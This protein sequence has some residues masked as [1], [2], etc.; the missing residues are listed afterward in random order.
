MILNYFKIA[1]RS[2]F[3][4]KLYTSL[5]IAGLTFGLTCFIL[6]ALYVF[7]EL[8]YDR[9]FTNSARTYRVIEQR[10]TEGK[11]SLIPA[12]SYLLGGE[13]KKTIPEIEQVTRF[14]GG[15]RNNISNP[16]N[17]NKFYETMWS[18]DAAFLEIF[19][20]PLVDGDRVNALKDP[21]S[22]V[23]TEDLAIKL[24]NSKQ[25]VGKMVRI[26]D[27]RLYKVTA[28]LKELPSNTSFNFNLLISESTYSEFDFYKDRITSDW[29][30]NTQNT[31]VVLKD[32]AN[33]FTVSSRM[34]NLV[35]A[36]RPKTSGITVKYSL[37][38]LN[39]I[40]FHSSHMQ[41]APFRSGNRMYIFIFSLVA[42]FLLVIACINYMNLTTAHASNRFKEIGI[43]KA[44]GA[45]RKNLAWQFLTESALITGFSFI[46]SVLLVNAA[47][48][49]FNQFVDKSLSLGFATDYRIWF[50]AIG[51]ALL[52]SLL[53]G[54]YP[55]IMLS[56][57]QPVSLLKNLVVRKSGGVTLRRSLVV[58]QF[59]LSVV[60]II[61]TIVLYQ[62]IQF[63]KNKNLGFQQDQLVVVDI[64]S[65]LVRRNA[66]TIKSE[67]G[68]I[69]E[70]QSVSSSSRVPGEW[71]TIPTV[72]IKTPGDTREPQNAYLIGADENFAKTFDI[73]LLKGRNFINPGDTSSILLNETAAALLGIDQAAEQ[74][75][76]IP[77]ANFGGSDS[78]LNQVFKARVIGITK[79]FH[80]QSLREKIAPLVLAYRNNP[81]HS[82]DYFTAW[83]KTPDASNALDEMK[84]VLASIDPNHLF[85]HHFLDEQLALFYIEDKRRET[86]L[87]WVALAIVFISCLGLFGLATYAAEQRIKEI[88]VRK[89]LGASV[90]GISSLL[91]KDFLKLVLIANGVAFPVAY[92]VMNKW[93]NEFAYRIDIDVWVFV[94]AGSLALLIALLTVG[95]QAIRAAIA[96]P[97]KSLRM[98]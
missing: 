18:T 27:D 43:R 22:V 77:S 67:F 86:I 93:L 3:R 66:E 14:F 87:I 51:F 7:N 2:F 44:A 36:N 82:I 24:F 98:E 61:A 73:Q 78:P 33:P 8:T 90:L 12:V 53:S 71:K 19:D 72:K 60:M 41:G 70:V 37:Q 48:P 83:L 62:Q 40:Y 92:Y 32:R 42:L 46:L 26:G 23:L 81:V 35:E 20:H 84:K 85:E 6:I 63:I 1:Y 95:F 56:G 80:F 58:F 89:V 50:G 96:N 31:F 74:W 10:T 17:L 94:V 69:A 54:S 75:V 13:S 9:H 28:V 25:V 59:T 30:S 65:G 68:R 21:Y 29:S 47:L 64:N 45:I 79:D 11:E 88:G 5:N 55:A 34:D 15:G 76:E 49:F 39:D 16:D 52:V 4:N 97:I 91:S 38:P 57:Y